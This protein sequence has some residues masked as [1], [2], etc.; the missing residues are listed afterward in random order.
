MHA[1]WLDRAG[2]SFATRLG[3]LDSHERLIAIHAWAIDQVIVKRNG[4][5]HSTS[6]KQ[7]RSPSDLEELLNGLFDFAGDQMQQPYQCGVKANRIFLES[8]TGELCGKTAK[9]R[10]H[11]K[12][13]ALLR[14]R[15]STPAFTRLMNDVC[16]RGS[17]VVH[18]TLRC[19]VTQRTARTKHNSSRFAQQKVLSSK[20]LQSASQSW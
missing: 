19:S 3:T 20:T 16:M 17:R 10:P 6:P 7:D 18:K 8:S 2:R 11:R 5:L 14:A 15:I 13:L 1:A 4:V 12:A 9:K